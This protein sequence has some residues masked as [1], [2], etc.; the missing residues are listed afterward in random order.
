MLLNAGTVATVMPGGKGSVTEM[1]DMATLL[2]AGLVMVKVSVVAFP[3]IMVVGENALAM[4]GDTN[5]VVT[6]VA[7]LLAVLPAGSPPPET[8][9]VLLTLGTAAAKTLTGTDSAADAALSAS[10]V[11]NVQLIPVLPATLLP[12]PP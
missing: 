12:A 2:V 1:P 5:T 4:L 8:V 11:P 7:E 10:T 3:A 6:S 9:A